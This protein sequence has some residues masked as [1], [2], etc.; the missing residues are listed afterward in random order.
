[1]L[2]ILNN[3]ELSEKDKIEYLLK[4]RIIKKTLVHIH[5]IPKSLVKDDILKSEEYLG[6]YGTIVKFILSSKTSQETNKKAYS[7]YVTYSTELEAA[8]AILCVDSLLI[9]G[10]II[11]AFFGTTKYCSYFL[12]NEE[13]PNFVRCIFLH[14]YINNNDTII[15]NNDDFTYNAHINLAK[16]IINSSLMEV[17][18]LIQKMKKLNQNIFPTINF[19]FLNV[20][21]KEKYF[22]KG[23]ISYFKS[24]DDNDNYFSLNNSIF[25]QNNIIFNNNTYINNN[26]NIFLGGSNNINNYYLDYIN[27]DKKSKF[28]VTKNLIEININNS[29][30]PKELYKI[31]KNSIY[32]ILHAKPYFMSLKNINLQKLELEYLIKDLSKNGMDIY[33]LLLG[34]LDPVSHLL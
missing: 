1:M 2:H 8:M 27:N 12:N 20:E 17:K 22:K 32:Q 30:Y 18:Y 14:K 10:K 13:C 7:A 3:N 34:C 26:N 5:G 23:N 28:F 31:F 24:N 33:E 29:I 25:P 16:K 4:L 19:I 15:N 21:Q 11:R 9:Q 6:Q